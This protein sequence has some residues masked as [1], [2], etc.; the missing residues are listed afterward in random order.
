MKRGMTYVAIPLFSEFTG[1]QAVVRE[2]LRRFRQLTQDAVRCPFAPQAVQKVGRNH[3]CNPCRSSVTLKLCLPAQ[4]S[5]D[6]V[7]GAHR[8]PALEVYMVRCRNKHVAQYEPRNCCNM[9]VGQLLVVC[10]EYIVV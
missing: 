2:A 6:N 5:I 4:I 10:I 1:H 3:E 9:D 7:A 8:L